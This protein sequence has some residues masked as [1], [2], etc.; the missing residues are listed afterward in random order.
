MILRKLA[1]VSIKNNGRTQLELLRDRIRRADNAY[2]L[3]LKRN[4]ELRELL[5]TLYADVLSDKSIDTRPEYVTITVP[6]DRALDYCSFG[7]I[8]KASTHD[9]PVLLLEPEGDSDN[10][11]GQEGED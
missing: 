8:L 10:S 1:D 6:V 11:E 4:A 7:S 2:L 9:L 5:P 3:A